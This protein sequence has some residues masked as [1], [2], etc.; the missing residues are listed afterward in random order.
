MDY[1]TL[2]NILYDMDGKKY[3]IQV[4]ERS[5]KA[6]KRLVY[7]YMAVEPVDSQH[8]WCVSGT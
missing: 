3:D 1:R 8:V 2:Y 4:S 6:I 7:S 5:Q